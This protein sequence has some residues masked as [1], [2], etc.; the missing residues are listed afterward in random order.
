MIKFSII[1]PVFKRPD[2]VN[3]F[4]KSIS[5]QTF[6]EYEIVMVDGSPDEILHPVIEKYKGDLPLH[7]EQ[8]KLLGASESRNLGCKVAKGEYLVFIDS[9]CIVP[10]Q[11]LES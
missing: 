10:P 4:L 11:Y 2:E 5:L 7:Y 6:S 1:V 8:V 3:E 9:D